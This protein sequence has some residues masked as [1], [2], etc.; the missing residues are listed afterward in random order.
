MEGCSLSDYWDFGAWHPPTRRQFWR[1]QRRKWAFAKDMTEHPTLA[2][3]EA[4]KVF[5]S[6]NYHYPEF[7]WRRQRVVHGY[8]VDFYCARLNM[9]VEV[10]GAS[11]IGREEQDRSKDANL[12]K[13]G[14]KIVYKT[15]PEVQ[16][17]SDASSTV[18]ISMKEHRQISYLE[19][20]YHS[21]K[22]D[23]LQ[24]NMYTRIFGKFDLKSV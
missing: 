6:L 23:P 16:E 1:N 20:L 11:H 14:V 18:D 7:V 24:A 8:I 5:Q 10:D 4:W 3:S 21:V 19:R 22:V 17:S 2:E 15:I 13:K 12:A 9:A